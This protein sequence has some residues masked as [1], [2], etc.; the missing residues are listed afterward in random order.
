MGN[1]SNE[2][3]N[4]LIVGVMERQVKR[5]FVIII[6]LLMGLIGTNI[7]WIL[8]ESQ[9]DTY[10]ITQETDGGDNIKVNG[11]GYGDI[12]YGESKTDNQD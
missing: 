2:A 6:I 9:F 7:G 8:Y 3:V 1:V 4:D 5:M 11:V 10:E 12:N